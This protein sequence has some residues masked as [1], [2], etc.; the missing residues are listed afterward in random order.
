MPGP[1]KIVN[2]LARDVSSIIKGKPF[3]KQIQS[4]SC[5]DTSAFFKAS[6]ITV[7][8]HSRWCS[9]VSRGWNP[10][11]GGVTYVCLTLERTWVEPSGQCL[12]IP[13]PNLLAE[14]S[15]PRAIYGLSITSM[16]TLL[17]RFMI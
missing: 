4:M 13:A 16:S 9:A 10:S 7:R 2:I 5:I 15:S 1:E 17:S 6:L 11:P 8:A 3:V 14:P 12:I